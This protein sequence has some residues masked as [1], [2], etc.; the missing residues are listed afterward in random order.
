MK[1]RTRRRLHW[2]VPAAV[3]LATAGISS[4]SQVL[5]AGADP[6][7]VLP[8]LTPAQLLDK[9]HS[10][11]VTTL[12]GDVRLSSHLGLPDLSALGVGAARSSTC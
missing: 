1:L 7:P 4:L 8:V 11:S 10:A 5:P 2:A 9:V 12:S 6:S 3:L